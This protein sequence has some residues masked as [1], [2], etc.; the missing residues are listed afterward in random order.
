MAT[1]PNARA[2]GSLGYLWLSALVI[3][4]DQLS[5]FAVERGLALYQ[6]VTVLP[7]LEIT[8]LHN[9]GAA[10]SFLANA[11]GWQRWLFTALAL[12]VSGALVRW[13]R[14]IERGASVLACAVALILGGALGN[15]IDRLRLGQVIDFIYAHWQQHYFPAFNV[16]DS[17]ICVGA[18]L[19]LLDT[20]LAGTRGAASRGRESPPQ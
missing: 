1:Q 10:F 12:G 18:G 15:V 6:S 4:L 5:K 9:S 2:R 8:R 20:W 17:A 11:A 3:A 19:L 7:V 16:A 13:L 14:H